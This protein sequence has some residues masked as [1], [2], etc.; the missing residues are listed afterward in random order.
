MAE[1]LVEFV[2]DF[3]KLETG[4]DQLVSSN[5]ISK[6]MAALFTDAGKSLDQFGAK[7]SKLGAGNTLKPA[8]DAAKKS[9]S[10]LSKSGITDLGELKKRVDGISKSFIDGFGEGVEQALTEA[11]VSIKDFDAA[12]VKTVAT[13]KSLKS[14]L[15]QINEEL[16]RMKL[17]GQGNTQQ[18]Q[19]LSKKA[20]EYR[21]AVRD[22][23]EEI[24]RQAS[25][26]QKLD[27][28]I[29]FVTQLSSAYSVLQGIQGLVGKDN[30]ELQKTLLKVN[31]AMAILNGLQSIQNELKRKDNILTIA[32]TTL[33]KG[34]AAVVGTSTG[35][36]KAFRIAL[37][38][39]GIGLLVLAVGALVANWDKIRAA[40]GGVSDA[41]QD[42]IDNAE[43]LVEAG[44]DN[45]DL[46]D[47]QEE[48]LRRQGVSEEEIT[49]Q[50]INQLKINKQNLLDLLELR[51]ATLES[52]REA[53]QRSFS[54]TKT[55]IDIITIPVT[56]LSK[57][58]T[59]ITGKKLPTLGDIVGTKLFDPKEIDADFKE[60]EEKTRLET[61]RIQGQIDGLLNGIDDKRKAEGEKNA[62]DRAKALQ[63]QLQKE[64]E[65]RRRA[66]ED[67]LAFQKQ[68]LLIAKQ[69]TQEE[70]D[71]RK[72]VAQAELNLSL[73][74]DKL[75][76]N[77]RKLLIQEFFKDQRLLTEQFNADNKRKVLEDQASVIS[78]QLAALNLSF[79][80]RE[81]L[82]VQQ[83]EIERQL[84]L[85]AV[86]NNKTKEK[87]INAKFDKEIA[88]QRKKI[89]D[90][91][92]AEE[93]ADIQRNNVIRNQINQE[94]LSN[95]NADI[96]ARVQALIELEAFELSLIRKRRLENEQ[97]LIDGVSTLKQFSDTS[98][99]IANDEFVVKS[100]FEK[101]YSDLVET[102]SE[103]RIKKTQE[104]VNAIAD[105]AGQALQSL[106]G[107]L[108]TMAANEDARIEAQR[109][110]LERL[111]ENGIITQKEYE[112]RA[113]VIDRLDRQSKQKQAEREK[114]LAL[115][116]AFVSGAAAIV[117]SIP[118]GPIVIAATSAL[119]AAQIAAIIARK[120]PQFGKGTKSAPKGFAE[121]GETGTELIQ[122]KEGYYVAEH[123]QVVW[124][125][126]GE[127]VFNPK[128]TKEI[129][130]YKEKL[131]KENFYNSNNIKETNKEKIE[132]SS[133]FERNFYNSNIEII[134]RENIRSPQ[135]N[136]TVI[137][138]SS[139]VSQETK[140]DYDKM[141]KKIGEEIAKH[142]RLVNNIDANGYSLYLIEG[143]NKSKYLNNRFTFK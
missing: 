100:K 139:K 113:K 138:N 11:G 123:P 23:N 17:N 106:R 85:S 75:T 63:D 112:A 33:Q 9:I 108:E 50:K 91:A 131:S 89:R 137:N 1:I 133:L 79:E 88:E 54:I 70:L 29:R 51:R 21:G 128:E 57:L 96:D 41:Q 32:Q 111:R 83:L 59:A 101:Q 132:K 60:L 78:A 73:D 49:R 105:F 125:K 22:V 26:T 67:E 141:A 116:D 86:V 55:I 135:P 48:T 30:E 97:N 72:G 35:A 74:N 107:F 81:E 13:D 14:E 99:D 27:V 104:V 12:L 76:F 136:V 90:E 53:Q 98:K 80:E 10:D 46:L 3:T 84:Q 103:K 127:K 28:A 52:Q 43:K 5:T 64:A 95:P 119:V 130:N 69:G 19:E 140:V 56:A 134:T 65:A 109:D 118:K 34:Y 87:E 143:L 31:S 20:G 102:E 42:L 126:G 44:E 58:L 2:P 6:E 121:V 120:I 18:Y 82:T 37:A 66:L 117:D 47:A 15:R 7:F 129:F 36:L 68:K 142:P 71:A 93:L 39:T 45:L 25:D 124:F 77:Q 92:F 62:A 38:S 16:A 40:M 8:I 24:N 122:T 115:F 94:V 110:S 114:A 61:T 4:V